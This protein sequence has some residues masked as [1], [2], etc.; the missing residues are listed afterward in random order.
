MP[1]E[2]VTLMIHDLGC[3]GGSALDCERA[4]G[5]LVGVMRAYVSPATEVAYVEFDPSRVCA[6]DLVRAVKE[7]GFTPGQPVRL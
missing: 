2:R 1:S 3:R 6:A 5:R 7:A 4:L